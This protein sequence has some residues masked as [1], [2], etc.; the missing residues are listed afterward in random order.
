MLYISLLYAG[1]VGSHFKKILE[2][3]TGN[4]LFMES[5]HQNVKFLSNENWLNDFE[6][7]IDST[8]HIFDLNIKLQG[9]GQLV[10]KM[11]EHICAFEKK[12][13]L[14]HFQLS[15]GILMH[16]KCLTTR[17]LKFPDLNCTNYG[18]SVQKLSEEFANR[19][20]DFR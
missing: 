4:K 1:S 19:F 5:K 7:L 10:N 6:F 8:Q 11:F 9:K 20:R 12:L 17:K 14:F 16:F 18:A 13:E 2:S 3:A 15:R